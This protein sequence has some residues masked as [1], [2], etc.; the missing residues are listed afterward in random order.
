M[1]I[2]G[3]QRDLSQ[4]ALAKINRDFRSSIEVQINGLGTRV[5]AVAVAND[6]DD[7]ESITIPCDT[8]EP[9][10]NEVYDFVKDAFHVQAVAYLDLGVVPIAFTAKMKNVFGWEI[11]IPLPKVIIHRYLSPEQKLKL[12]VWETQYPKQGYQILYLQA[13]SDNHE[14]D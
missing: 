10:S 9:I 11:N 2:Q 14:H 5:F 8:D 3:N 12:K 4:E 13:S 6:S 7:N 1:E